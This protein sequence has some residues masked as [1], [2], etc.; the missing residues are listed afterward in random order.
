M[1]LTRFQLL[2]LAF[3]WG[4]PIGLR[5]Q[6]AAPS[7]AST[8]G[9]LSYPELFEAL[10]DTIAA[11]FYNPEFI[12]NQFPELTARYAAKVNKVQGQVAFSLLVNDYLDEFKVSHTTYYTP[13][14]NSYYHL[15]AIFS[16]LPAVQKIFDGLDIQYPSIGLLTDRDRDGVKVT[17]VLP[18]SS[19]ETAGFSTGD[20]LL[21]QN[22]EPYNPVGLRDLVGETVVFGIARQKDQM[23][24]RATPELINPQQELEEACRQSARLLEADGKKIAYIRLWSFAGE[25]YYDLLKEQVLYGALKDAESLILDLRGGWGGANPEYLNLFNASVPVMEF[26]GRDGQSFSYDSQWRKPVCLL[27]DGSVRSGKEILAFGFR[28]YDIGKVIGAKTAGAVTGGRVFFLPD[29]SLLYLAVNIATVDGQ[30]LEGAGVIPDI[31]APDHPLTPADETLE[32]AK[33]FLM[34][35]SKK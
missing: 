31:I 35:E 3:L 6:D 2:V 1:V 4:L 32:A 22:G 8:S 9:G 15:S 34:S 24:L 29:N 28:K 10:T 5:A 20:Y 25:Q 12:K 18:G 30:I 11:Y 16:F 26:T 13:Q 23:E 27:T 21:S 7:T 14:D 17:G 33:Q 19:A